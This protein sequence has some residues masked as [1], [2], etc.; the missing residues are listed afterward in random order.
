MTWAVAAIQ[1]SFFSIVGAAPLA[2][3]V[4]LGGR[5]HQ[6]W[7]VYRH[8]QAPGKELLHVPEAR[9]SPRELQGE[10][11]DLGLTGDTD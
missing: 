4:D 10:R 11:P 8:D 6:V 1:T 7:V 3:V 2:E 9:R 5:V